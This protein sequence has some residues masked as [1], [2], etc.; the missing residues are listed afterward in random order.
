MPITKKHSTYVECGC[1]TL[2]DE[3]TRITI[4]GPVEATRKV[5]QFVAF[6]RKSN[7]PITISAMPSGVALS[8]FIAIYV[9]TKAFAQK[10]LPAVPRIV[11]KQAEITELQV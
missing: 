2:N 3:G 10:C 9:D 4:H 6:L 5:G 11:R 1:G 7:T 8:P